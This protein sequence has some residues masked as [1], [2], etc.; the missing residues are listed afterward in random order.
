MFRVPDGRV[1]TEALEPEVLKANP[2]R[3]EDIPLDAVVA[4]FAMTETEEEEIGKKLRG[5][6][7]F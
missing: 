4:G 1:L 2:I 7:Y 5:F 3:H 6:G